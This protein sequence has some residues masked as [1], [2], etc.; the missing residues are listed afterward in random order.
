[1]STLSPDL[2]AVVSLPKDFETIFGVAVTT[3]ASQRVR[4]AAWIVGERLSPPE[5][6]EIPL[7]FV[8]TPEHITHD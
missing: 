2:A 5:A 8:P 4:R 7:D 6:L 3:R 1:M